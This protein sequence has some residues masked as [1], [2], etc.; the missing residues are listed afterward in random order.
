MVD[1][2]I[3]DL[4]IISYNI[5]SLPCKQHLILLTNAIFALNTDLFEM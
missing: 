4:A 1:P 2:K 5:F 3:V